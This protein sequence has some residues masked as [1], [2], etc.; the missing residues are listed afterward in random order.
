VPA[1][2]PKLIMQH[3]IMMPRTPDPT[4]PGQVNTQG[5]RNTNNGNGIGN[6]NGNGT[7]VNIVHNVGGIDGGTLIGAGLPTASTSDGIDGR[8]PVGT[9]P[10]TASVA[11]IVYKWSPQACGVC[12][13]VFTAQNLFLSHCK[14]AHPCVEVKFRCGKCGRFEGQLRSVAGHYSRCTPTQVGGDSPMLSCSHCELKF[15]TKSGLSQ[16]ERHRHPVVRNAARGAPKPPRRERAGRVWSTEEVDCIRRW[17]VELKYRMDIN[18]EMARRLANGKTAKQ[19]SDK[20]RL[21]FSRKTTDLGVERDTPPE[22]GPPIGPASFEPDA[23]PVR[24]PPR[25]EDESDESDAAESLAEEGT[26]DDDAWRE[27]MLHAAKGVKRDQTKVSGFADTLKLLIDCCLAGEDVR[28]RLDLWVEELLVAIKA[29]NPDV[30]K[31]QGPAKG[32]GRKARKGKRPH[33]NSTTRK[34]DRYAQ[35]QKL[36]NKDKRKLMDHILDDRLGSEQRSGGPTPADVERLYQ[37]LWGT[38]VVETLTLEDG[39]TKLATECFSPILSAEVT[40]HLRRMRASSA[41]GPDG[42]SVT[43]LRKADPNGELST[44]LFNLC[45]AIAHCPAPFRTNRTVLIPKDGKDPR[46]AA[47]WRPLTIGPVLGRVFSGVVDGRLRGIVDLDPRQ[48]G[49]IPEP[50]CDINVFLLTEMHKV[51]KVD[52]GMV[53]AVLDIAK[54]F[55]TVPHT[56]ITKS[57]RAHGVPAPLTA[58]VASM[59]D[60]CRT[61]IS[62]DEADINITLRRGVKQGDPMSPLLWNLILDPLLRQIS[63]TGL[64][65]PLGPE[66]LPSLGFAD[67]LGLLSRKANEVQDL[68]RLAHT[69]LTKAGMSVAADKCVAYEIRPTGKTWVMQDPALTI[70]EGRIPF[71]GPADSIKYLGARIAPWAAGSNADV[72]GKFASGLEKLSKAPLKPPQK[73]VLLKTHYLPKFLGALRTA[74][75]SSRLLSKLDGMVRAAVKEWLKLPA[76]TSTAFLHTSVR[77]GGLGILSL[78]QAVPRALLRMAT[79]M[80][81]SHDPVVK[82]VAVITG[83][84]ERMSGKAAKLGLKWP[85]TKR[86]VMQAKGNERRSQRAAWAK[87]ANTGQQGKGVEEFFDAPEANTWLYD[88]CTLAPGEFMLACKMRTNTCQVKASLAAM[89]PGMPTKCRRCHLEPET[90]GHVVGGCSFTK[91]LRIARHNKIVDALAERVAQHADWEVQKEQV[92]ATNDPV[93]GPLLR[94]DLIF[95]NR[96]NG[97]ALVVDVTVPFEGDWRGESCLDLAAQRKR[98]KYECLRT[99]LLERS[100][101]TS[102][103]VHPFVMGVEVLSMRL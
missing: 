47:N 55:D 52:Q 87:L 57:L 78:R 54:A 33:K 102:V 32:K 31:E 103:T 37:G 4:P 41:A 74:E 81:A 1:R 27:G 8:P 13:V 46:M 10:S 72:E 36:F 56:L 71:L 40:M 59:Y 68:L 92:V 19:V 2:N 80:L 29:L 67:D 45:L 16:H 95:I 64:G 21:L 26:L 23:W 100:D 11:Y 28:E 85:M 65:I 42:V 35:A 9:G 76:C 5:G 83:M 96:P 98:D 58:L 73:L 60:D 24:P 91:K 17:E 88:P 49:F 99:A 66:R 69:Y 38:D 53:M 25:M 30:D 39:P 14:S 90:L 20:R 12:S 51:S 82:Q 84:N 6:G 70:G 3:N 48:K 93:Y 97:H 18:M 86:A 62:V 75:A 89:C 94:P 22:L 34:V 50:G 63:A 7:R 61:T 77:D 101:V 79:V 44:A 43:Q 15:S